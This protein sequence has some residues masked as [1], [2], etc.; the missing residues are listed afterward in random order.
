MIYIN[1]KND[2]HKQKENQKM[3]VINRKKIRK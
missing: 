3:I 1:R 2:S